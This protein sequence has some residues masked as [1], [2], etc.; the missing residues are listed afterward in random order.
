MKK[1]DKRE[2]IEHAGKV[3]E[4][5]KMEDNTFTAFAYEN[6]DSDNEVVGIGESPD[7]GRAIEIAI[8]DL[9]REQKNTQ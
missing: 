2:L 7:R 1:P 8:E 6:Y 5:Y 3:L 4:V 9:Q